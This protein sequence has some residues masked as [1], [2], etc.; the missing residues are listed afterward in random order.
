MQKPLHINCLALIDRGVMTG[1]AIIGQIMYLCAEQIGLSTPDPPKH[2]Q[3]R[4]RLSI[5]HA[6]HHMMHIR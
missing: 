3:S 1:N 6:F 2:C 4:G 5:S